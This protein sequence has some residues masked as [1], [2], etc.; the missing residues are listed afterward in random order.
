MSLFVLLLIPNSC[1]KEINVSNDFIYSHKIIQREFLPIVEGNLNGR[2]ANFLL[3]TGASISI[4]D[5]KEAKKYGVVVGGTIDMNVGGYG[6]VTNDLNSLTNVNL[7]LGSEQ[8]KDKFDGKDIEYLI[9]AIKSNTGVSIIGIIGNN[10]IT[11]SNL[12]L[13]FETN[14]LLKRE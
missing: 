10:N 12:I 2:K 4:L 5:L 9:K 3:D 7:F 1:K 6:G 8:M 11:S 14:N 13:D